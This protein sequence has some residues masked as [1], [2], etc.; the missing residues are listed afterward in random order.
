MRLKEFQ[1]A[2]H[3]SRSM[4]RGSDIDHTATCAPVR[5]SASVTKRPHANLELIRRVL[6]NEYLELKIARLV[7]EEDPEGVHSKVAIFLADTDGNTT[8]VAGEGCG[9][10]DA[11]WSGLLSRY[12]AEYQS[13]CSLEVAG[14]EVKAKLDTKKE[15]DGTDA[16]GEVT[17]ELRNSDQT[18]FSFSDASRS[19]TTSTSRVVLAAIEYFINAERAFITLFRSRQDAKERNREDLVARYT[20]ELSEVVKSTSYAEVLENM[21]KELS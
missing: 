16:V 18:R 1:R 2:G 5:Y 19:I 9:L 12:S 21:K 14:F 15:K 20:G 4:P 3:G 8:E 11:L 10:V 17:L 7:V 13:L 6:G